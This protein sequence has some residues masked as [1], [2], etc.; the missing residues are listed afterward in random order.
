[1]YCYL[2][3]TYRNDYEVKNEI[4]IFRIICENNKKKNKYEGLKLQYT[5]TILPDF[6]I[7]YSII[8]VE[9]IFESIRQYILDNI[10]LRQAAIVMCCLSPWSFKLYYIRFQE[11]VNQWV[12]LLVELIITTQGEYIEEQIKEID[13]NLNNNKQ[14]WNNFN[15]HLDNYLL[16]LSKL[17]ASPIIT[18]EMK[19]PYLHTLLCKT[20]MG[21]GP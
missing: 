18:E 4:C 9:S 17:K 14:K 6:L 7:P 10:T 19:Y 20:R 15:K 2:K 21:L 13:V 16:Q 3:R 1:M 8:P 11:L 12:I 5:L